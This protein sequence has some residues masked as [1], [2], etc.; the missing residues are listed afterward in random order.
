M[1]EHQLKSELVHIRGQTPFTFLKE[2]CI[3]YAAK[4]LKADRLSVI[5][6]DN[7]GGYSNASLFTR[8]FK[9]HHSLPPTAYQCPLRL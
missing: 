6:M 4:L 1:N 9:D 7:Q 2:V 5:Q 8:A 3:D